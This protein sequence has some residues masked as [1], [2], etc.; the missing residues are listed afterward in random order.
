MNEIARIRIDQLN[1]KSQIE[2]LKKKKEEALG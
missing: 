2:L 1:T